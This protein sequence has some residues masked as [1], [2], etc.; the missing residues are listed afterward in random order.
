[1]KS[2]LNYTPEELRRSFASSGIERFHADQ[3]LHWVCV[4]GVRE[5]GA[6]TNLSKGLRRQLADDWRTRSFERVATHRANDGTRK[7]VLESGDGARIESVLIPE[8]RRRTSC[9]SSQVG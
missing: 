8:E 1:M 3:V 7:L 4:R 2:V 9:V 6:M 5:F